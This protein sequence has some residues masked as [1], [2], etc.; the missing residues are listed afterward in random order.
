MHSNK[1]ENMSE[2]IKGI[3]NEI[4]INYLHLNK[5]KVGWDK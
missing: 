5:F 3:I 4:H 2:M 1:Y